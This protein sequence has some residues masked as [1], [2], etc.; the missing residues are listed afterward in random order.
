[1]AHTTMRTPSP[2]YDF[3]VIGGGIVGL[4]TLWSLLSLRPGARAL[5]IEKEPQ[6]AAHQT[7][8]NSGVI[9]SGIYYRPGSFKARFCVAGNRSMR[10]FCAERGLPHEVCGKLIVA[11]DASEIERLDALAARG[12]QNGIAI[13][14]LSLA[15][16]Q[17]IEPHVRCVA[18]LRVPSTG[19]VDYRLV[20]Q[21]F[22]EEAE[23]AGGEVRTGVRAVRVVAGDPQVVET[24]QE[25][26]LA[27]H[28]VNC[29]GLHSDHLA[30]QSGVSAPARVIPFRGE[31]YELAPGQRH[32]V[33]GLIYPVPDPSLPFLGVHLTRMVD[34]S[35]HAG[36]NAVLAFRR[37]G[38]R[39]ADL[40]VRDL[41]EIA[42]FPG[43]W[44]LAA[45]YWKVGAA[46]ALRS[47]SKARFVE[48]LRRLVPDI[49]AESLRP[50]EAGVRAQAVDRA[51]RLVDDFLI[52]SVP[53]STHVLNAPSPAATASIEIGRYVAETAI[54]GREPDAPPVA[55]GAPKE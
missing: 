38:Y 19:I 50:S 41:A 44:R 3:V 54:Y 20:S 16:A 46:E 36:P 39:W 32:L 1:M 2:T 37:E 12:E 4:A 13:E 52:L 18:A 55:S 33:R 24:P 43:A 26:I 7:G 49:S 30:R 14:R 48:S 51:G 27:R 42:T 35:V 5:L 23:Q 34:G 15:E 53:G 47:L 9:H 31:Y 25:R 10:A 8:R 22:R 21:R 40:S 11:T 6:I 45:T 29:A 17:A 28:V